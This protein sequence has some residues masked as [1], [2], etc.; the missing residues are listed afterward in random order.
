M[1]HWIDVCC[2]DDLQIDSGICVLVAGQQIAVFY[3]SLRGTVYATN[4]FDPF[5][6]VN[7]L[8]RGLTG[9]VDGQPFVASP[10]YK[11]RFNLETGVC[12]EDSSVSIQ[13]YPIRLEGDCVQ[14]NI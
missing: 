2:I 13:T 9:D 6:G 8:S 3:R 5:S 11:H 1:T 12:F 10:L 4:N 14:I 7:V